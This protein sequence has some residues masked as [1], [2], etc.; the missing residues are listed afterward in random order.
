MDSRPDVPLIP[1]AAEPALDCES[2]RERVA[3]MA[4]QLLEMKGDLFQL[5]ISSLELATRPQQ[6]GCA[7]ELSGWTLPGHFGTPK[8]LVSQLQMINP[9]A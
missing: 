3:M 6:E 1:E 4:Q 5:C 2:E 7:R 9:C 8:Y